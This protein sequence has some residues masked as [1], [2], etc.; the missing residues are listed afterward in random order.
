MSFVIRMA[1]VSPCTSFVCHSYVLVCHSYAT[2]MSFVCN[3][4]VFVYHLYILVCHSY[5]THM[6]FWVSRMYS[7]VT[8]MSL[9]DAPMSLACIFTMNR[10]DCFMHFIF[11]CHLYV[12]CI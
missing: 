11:F 4:Y 7:Y 8:R 2:R 9:V 1:F 6:C 10:C 3:L 5:V 12:T